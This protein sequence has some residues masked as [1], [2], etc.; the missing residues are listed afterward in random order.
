MPPRGTPRRRAARPGLRQPQLGRLDLEGR[1]QA[2]EQARRRLGEVARLGQSLRDRVLG[3]E[4][5]LDPPPLGHVLLDAEPV[6][7][8][9]DLDGGDPRRGDDL[10]PVLAP[11]APLAAPD[12]FGL[13]PRDH[14]A[15]DARVLLRR[16]G[17]LHRD[18]P[19]EQLAGRVAEHPVQRRVG[20]G[21]RPV[22]GRQAHPLAHALQEVGVKVLPL[23]RGL[24]GRDVDVDARAAHRTPGRVAHHATPHQD[25]ARLP[26]RPG[27]PA[28]RLVPLRPL[29]Q[30]QR[31]R[32]PQPPAVLR[33]AGRANPLDRHPS[34]GRLEP[35]QP[36]ELRRAPD[37][38]GR[39]VVVPDPDSGR[40]LGEVEQL[41]AGPQGVL[42][43][44][45]LG[46]V[47]VD[48]DPPRRPPVGA[49]DRLGPAR[50]PADLAAHHH[51]ELALDRR[52]GLGQRP[53]GGGLEVGAVVR[54][55]DPDEVGARHLGPG[56]EAEQPA[57]GDVP[58]LPPGREVPRPHAH[59]AG[60][61]R[62]A[63]PLLARPGR[64][65]R[66]VPGLVRQLTGGSDSL[67]PHGVS[68]T[69]PAPV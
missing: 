18:V 17:V 66:A 40:P 64:R 37:R 39:E 34:R 10:A 16:V 21:D 47:P 33:V 31:Q 49:D 45:L 65:G 24:A 25:P 59:A 26:A 20:V 68:V 55:H 29:G 27:H 53:G 30:G 46:D 19:P 1:A 14:L 41:V 38:R 4:P 62:H 22:L 58:L 15:D 3:R 51:P 52:P 23:L 56:L 12:P 7:P 67:C 50:Q 36:E 2:P 42:G 43:P 44:L 28:L 5:P 48:P 60:G 11:V 63:Q 13:Q 35:E 69:E 57:G 32:L 6:P 8:P 61:E 54:V 9:A